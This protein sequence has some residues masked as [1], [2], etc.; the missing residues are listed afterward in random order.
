ML[1]G[2]RLRNSHVPLVARLLAMTRP[3][4][5]EHVRLRPPLY[6]PDFPF[7]LL[8]SQ[9]SGCTTVVKWFLAQTGLLEEALAYSPWVHD[10]ENQVFKRR[11]N[12]LAD[13]ARAIRSGRH[14][15][16]KIVRDPMARAPSAFL[17]LAEHGVL[18]TERPHWARAHWDHVDRWLAARGKDP[19]EGLTF[20]D[21]LAMLAEV[22]ARRPH[23]VDLHLSPQFVQ[24][25]E[26]G[27]DQVVPIERFADWATE[28]A[29]IHGLKAIDPEVWSQSGHHHRVGNGRTR[30]LGDRPETMPILRGSYANKRFP[31]SG[32]FV[33]E[34][35]IPAIRAVY[36]A[37]FAAYGSHYGPDS[38]GGA[39]AG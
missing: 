37:D 17:V 16:V 12:Y 29:A 1:L 22:E 2:Q 4:L 28:A 21:H 13:T 5:P 33:N 30:A 14:Q 23:L 11:P 24:G 6:H 25:E 38:P 20:L 8:W 15:V 10:Y 9:K 27:L 39:V 18:K 26:E 31:S 7:V 34:R 3:G 36:A 32:A 35:S 19:A